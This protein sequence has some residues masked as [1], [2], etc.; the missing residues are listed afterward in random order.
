[1][2]KEVLLFCPEICFIL[3]KDVDCSLRNN[4]KVGLGKQSH[5]FKEGAQMISG[6][7]ASVSAEVAK[8]ALSLGEQRG[9][10]KSKVGGRGLS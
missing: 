8:G 4:L 9:E 2:C 3:R 10:E 1:M 5:S 7:T 6:S